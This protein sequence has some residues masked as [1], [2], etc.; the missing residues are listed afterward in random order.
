M[1]R[2]KAEVL[3]PTDGVVWVC[4]TAEPPVGSDYSDPDVYEG[5]FPLECRRVRVSARDVAL[6]GATG[7]ELDAKLEVRHAPRLDADATATFRGRAYE[8]TQVEDRGATAYL[9]LAEVACEG[10]C[11]LLREVTSRDG[12]GVEAPVASPPVTVFVRRDSPAASH[13]RDA[14]QDRLMPSAS[15]TLRACD[16]GGERRVRRAGV[17]Y[18][19]TSVEHD[20]RW[21]R[22]RCERRVANHV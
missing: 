16:Y 3:A 22:L 9:W 7:H 14:G 13:A 18:D 19:V 6:A 1:L 5:D 4:S 2:R 15:L 12:R 8:V 20:G 17:T 11:D 10:T 21:V